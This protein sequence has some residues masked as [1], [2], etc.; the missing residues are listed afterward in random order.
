MSG[1]AVDDGQRCQAKTRAGSQCSRV[2]KDGRY[3]FQHGP[4][5]DTIEQV[6]SR[7]PSTVNWLSEELEQRAANATD[8][9]RDVYM[10]LLD[11]QDGILD[12]IEGFR[13]G[14]VTL[15]TLTTAFRETAGKTDKDVSKGVIIGGIFG[16]P[17][18]GPGIAAGA[19]IGGGISI[20]L[21]DTDERVLVGIPTD[22]PP[23]DAD[24]VS[25]NHEAITENKTIQLAIRAAVE[26]GEEDWIRNS[27]IRDWDMESV[28]QSLDSLP[29]FSS[30]SES[31]SGWYVRDQE[32]DEVV[33]LVFG[34]PTDFPKS[35]R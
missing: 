1:S 3:C 18:G 9:R 6:S 17:F 28:A 33:R 12:T 15:P 16:A 27:R 31:L 26:Q 5:S 4:D 11:I 29:N 21:S 8:I 7:P 34:E 19:S 20:A 35:Y 22:D 25:N 2:A 13:S 24:L 14:K 32:S 23:E 10:N 30:G